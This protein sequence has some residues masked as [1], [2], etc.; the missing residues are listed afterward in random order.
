MGQLSV[1]LSRRILFSRLSLR[2][3]IR[4]FAGIVVA[5]RLVWFPCHQV[6]FRFL[7]FAADMRV[8]LW[9]D[10]TLGRRL[11]VSSGNKEALSRHIS[12][13]RRECPVDGGSVR[14]RQQSGWNDLFRNSPR[15]G[16]N[17]AGPWFPLQTLRLCRVRDRVWLY[18]V[19]LA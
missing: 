9:G 1:L 17:G 18:R 15:L 3:S 4:A 12:A 19:Q 14:S 11:A 5:G 7:R 2:Q 8:H 10:R 6:W 16:W 13:C